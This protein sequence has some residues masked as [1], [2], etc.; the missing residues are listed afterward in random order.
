MFASANWMLFPTSFRRLQKKSLGA[1][2]LTLAV[3]VVHVGS[4]E[5]GLLWASPN[6]HRFKLLSI[7][8]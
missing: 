5:G 6:V 1:M 7:H 2:I 4:Q 8:I 3:H